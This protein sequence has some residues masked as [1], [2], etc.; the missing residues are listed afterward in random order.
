M[1]KNERFGDLDIDS[2]LYLPQSN[3]QKTIVLLYS[4]AAFGYRA[5]PFLGFLL[6]PARTSHRTRR[7]QAYP[8][9]SLTRTLKT[10]YAETTISGKPSKLVP[11]DA[12]PATQHRP[13]IRTS[14]QD[15]HRA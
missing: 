13:P 2:H 11:R 14:I 10:Q 15:D 1:P 6:L 4:L 3:E 9:Q 5:I 12:F 7:I 8:V